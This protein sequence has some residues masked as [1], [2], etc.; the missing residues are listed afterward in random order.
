MKALEED[1]APESVRNYAGT[2]PPAR[3]V[4][5]GLANVSQTYGQTLN[6]FSQPLTWN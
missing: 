3:N 4:S 1:Q 5:P 2:A 6:S